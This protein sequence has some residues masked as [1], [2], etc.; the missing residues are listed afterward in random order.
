MHDSSIPHIHDSPIPPPC[1]RS[2]RRAAY[3]GRHGGEE[4]R[5]SGGQYQ[6]QAKNTVWAL[7]PAVCRK[8]M[9]KVRQSARNASSLD[10]SC[11]HEKKGSGTALMAL[12]EE[13]AE[14]RRAKKGRRAQNG[15][16]FLFPVCDVIASGRVHRSRTHHRRLP[17]HPPPTAPTTAAQEKRQSDKEI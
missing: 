3:A 4:I 1:M 10:E 9:P 8:Y 12:V 17:H 6:A 15:G 11:I 5:E 14:E 13:L 16:F 7:V 2:T